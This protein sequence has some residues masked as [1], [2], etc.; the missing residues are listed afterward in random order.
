MQS[1]AIEEYSVV[2][3]ESQRN[4][5]L[6]RLAGLPAQPIH[7]AFIPDRL[8]L[9]NPQASLTYI[10]P[11]LRDRAK[12]SDGPLKVVIATEPQAHESYLRHC[13]SEGYDTLTTK[14]LLV[15]MRDGVFDGGSIYQR[16]KDLLEWGKRASGQHS[17]IVLDRHHEIYEKRIRS[18]IAVMMEKLKVPITS[19]NLKTASGV[20]NLPYEYGLREDHPYKY[21]YGMLMHGAYHYVD[22]LTRLL[23][24]NR[25]IYGED[26]LSLRITG[27][28]AFP[29]DQEKRLPLSIL[30]R[31]DNY[32]EHMAKFDSGRPYGETD[33]VAS[34]ALCFRRSRVALCLGT[35]ALEQT[36]PGMR[37]W[38]AFPEVPYNV[39]GRLHCTDVDVRLGTLFAMNGH[40]TKIPISA[41]K[42]QVDLRGKNI[43]VVTSRSNALVTGTQEFMTEERIT[44][45]YGNSFSYAAESTLFRDWIDGKNTYSDLESHLP[46][47]AV[48][49]ALARMIRSNGEIVEI[50]F[51]FA[52]PDWPPITHISNAIVHDDRVMQFAAYR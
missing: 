31:L 14:P 37:S 45:P 44:Q 32:F 22:L 15:P 17:L 49:S 26:E 33:I 43:G 28:S 47:A 50:E 2:D 51:D 23:Q 41:R 5:V 9:D 3:L 8:L 18:Q 24:M 48:T 40:V 19:I 20:W 27:F 12:E 46:T 4:T 35:I 11:F 21:G 25:R 38:G 30:N 16:T 6:R 7:T 29:K 34:F 1:G 39:N 52:E 13:M 42:G 10:A 36:T